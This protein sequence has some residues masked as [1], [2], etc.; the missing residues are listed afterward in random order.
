MHL[1]QARNLAGKSPPPD[2][3]FSKLRIAEPRETCASI[4]KCCAILDAATIDQH[5]LGRSV[6][7]LNPRRDDEYETKEQKGSVDSQR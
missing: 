3:D 1:E 6:A 7:W 2:S 4:A 5:D